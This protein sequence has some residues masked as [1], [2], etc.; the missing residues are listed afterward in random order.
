MFPFPFSFIAAAADIP[1]EQI[2]NAEAMSF[3]GVD[4]YVA[5]PA[6]PN[7][8]DISISFW[9]KYSTGNN[10]FVASGDGIFAYI[11]FHAHFG[12]LSFNFANVNYDLTTDIK[13]GNWHHVVVT[14]DQPASTVKGYTDGS[15][16]ATHTG[17]SAGFNNNMQ[18]IGAWKT[19]STGYFNGEIDEFAVFNTAL[20][21]EKI[22][23]IY[24]A[25]AVVGGVP[26]TANLFTGGLDSSLVYWNR[27][28]DS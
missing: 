20:S 14:Y 10:A 1:V 26:Q 11:R 15:L 27:M 12:E 17:K 7:T 25:T 16:S 2:A 5:F 24:D 23:Q 3:N 6:T 22:T 19:G 18:T 13:D 4:S 9:V 21:P 8:G 28:G